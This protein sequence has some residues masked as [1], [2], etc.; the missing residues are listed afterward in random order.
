MS[1]RAKLILAFLFTIVVSISSIS[2]LVLTQLNK[3]SQQTFKQSSMSQLECVDDFINEFIQGTK[4]NMQYLAGLEFSQT[5]LGQLDKFFGPGAISKTSP[6]TMSD[7]EKLLHQNFEEMLKTHPE[8]AYVYIGTKD[9][10]ISICPP[11]ELSD[12]DP[13]TRPWYT[14]ATQSKEIT[15]I[16]PAYGSTSG[17]AVCSATAKVFDPS[18]EF[19]GVLTGDIN[20]STLTEVTGEIKLGRTGYVLIME[21]DGTILSDP[22]KPSVNFKKATETGI[23]AFEDIHK[24]DEGTFVS[25]VG[26]TEKLITV[27]TSKATGW[28]LAYVID[29]SEVFQASNDMLINILIAA[30]AICAILLLGAWFLANTLSR[31]IRILSASAEAVA[32]GDFDALPQQGSFSAEME[33]LNIGMH[34]MMNKLMGH[35]EAAQKSSEE[36]RE[37][38]LQAEEA[39]REAEKARAQAEAAT[40]EGMLQAANSLEE[41]V[42][43]VT[44]AS[45]ELSK[46][47]EQ[48]ENGSN[49]Q[50]DRL[51]EVASAMDQ[52]AGSILDVAENASQAAENAEFARNEAQ[53]GRQVVDDVIASINK[54][55]EA[56]KSME[57]GLENLGKQAE[58]IGD[59]MN[60]ITDIADQTNLLALNAAIEAARAGEAGR[61]FA[62]V[63]DEVRK[64]AEKTMTA[65]KEVG[66]AVSSI[67]SGTSSSINDMSN[68]SEMIARS[69]DLASKAG[70][71][72]SSIL[73]M[74]ETNS[75]QIRV[76]ATASEEQSSAT[77]QMN[78]G[79]DEISAIAQETASSM[80]MSME[81]VDELAHLSETLK[82]LIE[83]LKNQ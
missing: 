50:R 24:T 48:A 55:H 36:A 30:A 10:A 4:N 13:R 33:I 1:L 28:K 41:I 63:A 37:K 6:E 22:A 80:G 64:L 34:D 58:G 19:I 8:Y 14:T 73:G 9:G 59:I 62:V 16:S 20:L 12:Y 35:I 71:A 75:D 51:T 46:Q 83:N 47:I 45:E 31:P 15:M 52:V 49:I 56:S 67:Q 25:N 68:A 11:L 26:E 72:L 17:E 82:G 38:S 70:D 53:S 81:A 66:D 21:K 27:I 74:V 2:I 76:I 5:S 77:E 39:M 79:T 44:S 42:E 57:T 23:K 69:T 61:G 78:R 65:T 7:T 32:D 43:R 40:K 3:Y 29:S 54:V 60:V 18:G